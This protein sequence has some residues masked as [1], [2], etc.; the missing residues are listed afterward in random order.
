MTVPESMQVIVQLCI[1][2]L[3]LNPNALVE[4]YVVA[5]P[6]SSFHHR[7]WTE[8]LMYLLDTHRH[9]IAPV[10]ARK[11]LLQREWHL[12]EIRHRL[13]NLLTEVFGV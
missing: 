3:A 8:S 6:R 10:L 9:A 12:P 7:L 2:G 1:E 11:L 4:I 5:S 13:Q